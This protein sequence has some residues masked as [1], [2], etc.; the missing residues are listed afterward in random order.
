MLFRF[1][2]FLFSASESDE[3]LYDEEEDEDEELSELSDEELLE[4]ELSE[5]SESDPVSLSEPVIVDES[6]SESELLSV[7]DLR[8]KQ[9]KIKFVRKTWILHRAGIIN[10]YLRLPFQCLQQSKLHNL[11]F[12]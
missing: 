2:F 8:Q 3:S 4:E 10:R 12:H 6:E 5:L 11:D 7:S 9:E 1:D